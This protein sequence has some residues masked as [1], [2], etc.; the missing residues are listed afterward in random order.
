MS[1]AISVICTFFNAQDTLPA[2]LDSLCAQTA[3]D[4]EFIL[5]DDCSTDGS[6]L[7][8]ERFCTEDRRFVLHQ[9]PI[10][11]RGHALNLAVANAS[12]DYIA[13]LDADDVAHPNWI[14]SALE[15]MEQNPEFAVVGFNRLYIGEGEHPRWQGDNRLADCP[16]TDVSARLG[17]ENAIS[18]SGV[19]MRKRNM[20][21]TGG[22]AAERNDHFDYD[23]WIRLIRSGNQVGRTD[24]IR[25]A[26]RYHPGQ[27]FAGRRG[28]FL[29]SL[30]LQIHAI[31]SAD[32]GYYNL[33]WLAARTARKA[34]RAF[35]RGFMR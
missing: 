23:L 28:Y 6:I 27:K 29:G 15:A 13:V 24:L 2:T 9:N 35:R 25:V 17:R 22:Y 5:V 31:R 30:L 7:I 14:E 12:A 4:A 10:R 3:K 1:A 34:A 20:L 19:V 33:V 16:P 21:E 32:S 11:G 8:A 18:H 26:K